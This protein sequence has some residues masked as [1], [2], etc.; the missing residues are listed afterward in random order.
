MKGG[1]ITYERK[2]E[3]DS[4][5]PKILKEMK[6]KADEMLDVFK[7][8]I[9]LYKDNIENMIK[10]IIGIKETYTD[11][12][13]EVVFNGHFDSYEYSLK[14]D[15]RKY[16]IE[17]LY[18]PYQDYYYDLILMF[19]TYLQEYLQELPEESITKVSPVLK[20]ELAIFENEMK[21]KK[22]FRL[23]NSKRASM[24]K[25]DSERYLELPNNTK[26][27]MRNENDES[28]SSNLF[29]RLNLGPTST[30]EN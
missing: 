15:E 30:Y 2:L 24:R 19:F 1:K 20:E 18:E 23:S 8:V 28:N 29:Q 10:F 5:L 9:S 11:N 27:K 3:L 21:K 14:P 7:V 25:G 22:S 4:L 13:I 17:Q 16:I 12:F 6:K 26:R